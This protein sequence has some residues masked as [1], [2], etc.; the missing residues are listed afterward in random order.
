V[1][2]RQRPRITPPTATGVRTRLRRT[3][4]QHPTS[5]RP[6]RGE[7]W[8]RAGRCDRADPQGLHA[9]WTPGGGY[10]LEDAHDDRSLVVTGPW[11]AEAAAILLRGEADGLVLNYAR[12]FGERVLAWCRLGG[13]AITWPFDEADLHA[14]RDHF[15]L[16]RLTIKEAPHL[17]SLS[18]VGNLSELAVLAIFLPVDF[19]T[20]VTSP[21]LRLRC[22]SS[23]CR[24]VLNRRD[25][26][27]RAARQPS[28][29]R[30][31]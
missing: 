18:G 10:V 16:R 5:A 25:R 7:R 23:S 27:R 19:T 15:K 11:S 30:A 26:R 20:S 14:F 1:V 8:V 13:L 17:E 12:G 22:D 21:S 9:T 29:P 6:V 24:T 2:R 4:R 28:L 3:I 31:Q